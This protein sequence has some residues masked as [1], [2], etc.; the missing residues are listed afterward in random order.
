MAFKKNIKKRISKKRKTKEVSIE[1]KNLKTA[2]FEKANLSGF[3]AIFEIIFNDLDNTGLTNCRKVCKTW[4]NFIDSKKFFWTRRIEMY[5]RGS[6]KEFLDQWNQVTK[7]TPTKEIEELC[8][9]LEQYFRLNIVRSRYSVPPLCIS[10]GTGSVQLSK[11]IIEKTGK[12]NPTDP[13]N[14]YTALHTAA[15]KGHLELC[16][17]IIEKSDD[18][19]PK[20]QNREITP[21]H[22]AAENG[23]FDVCKH[24]L[25]NV[26]VKNPAAVDGIT[27]LHRAA[28]GGHLDVC[29]LI[30][31]DVAVKN[32]EAI[33]RLTPLHFAAKGGHLDVCRLILEQAAVDN[34][35]T[36]DGITPLHCAAKGGHLDVC[37]LILKNAVDKNPAAN[38]GLTPLHIAAKRGHFEIL[39]LL[40]DENGVDM[41]PLFNGRTPLEEATSNGHFKSCMFLIENL[42]DYQQFSNFRARGLLGLAGLSFKKKCLSLAICTI[43]CIVLLLICI[44]GTGLV[45]FLLSS[46]VAKLAEIGRT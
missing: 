7:K 31:K 36:N 40:I 34:P 42:R 29:R 14:E 2:I 1:M 9:A 26:A 39:K 20:T 12:C 19:N 28:K 21:L 17:H 4:Q 25:D 15:E 41:R 8:L 37:R 3:P 6:S 24:I 32:P 10:A 44:L 16:M 38:D 18:K 46:G 35:A 13:I 43:E 11:R 45:L 30:L 23:H 27:P 5:D 22:L 33:D